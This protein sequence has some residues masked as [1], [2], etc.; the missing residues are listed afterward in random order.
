MLGCIQPMSSPMMN[1]M[2]G[3]VGCACAIALDGVKAVVDATAASAAPSEQR[4]RLQLIASS[5]VRPF[6]CGPTYPS[7]L[8]DGISKVPDMILSFAVS[9]RPCRR[10]PC[11]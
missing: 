10:Q 11:R 7:Q 3:F 6:L 9:L 8:C 1:T 2:L 5:L 4:V